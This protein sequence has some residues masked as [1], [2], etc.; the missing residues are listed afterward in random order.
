MADYDYNAGDVT[1][2]ERSAAAKQKQLNTY[3][4]KTINELT[5]YNAGTI[6]TL[7][8]YNKA[9]ANN[10][11]NFNSNT[12][13]S[14]AKYN[15]ATADKLRD[16][17]KATANSTAKYN[18][19]TENRLSDYNKKTARTLADYN[20]GI[21][22]KLAKKNASAANDTALYNANS[23]KNQVNQ[24][25]DNYNFA[26]RQNA[27]LRDVE[28]K[29]ASRKAEADRFEAQRN[30]R[31][32]ALGL[33]GSMNQAM[34]GSTIGNAMSMFSDR[35]D[36]ENSVYWQQ[37]Q[38][39]RNAIQNAYDESYN[40]NQVAK[41]DAV[42]NARKAIRDIQSDLSSNLNNIQGDLISSLGNIRTDLLS[43]LANTQKDLYANKRNIE[44]DRYNSVRGI[45]SDWY[46]NVRE[47]GGDLYNTLNG[48]QADRYS[49]INNVEGDW[50]NNWNNIQ[51]DAF[52][53]LRNLEANLAANLNNINPN[54]YQAP[55][56]VGGE[57][58]RSGG[59]GSGT[60]GSAI[61]RAPAPVAGAITS[62][63]KLP[64]YTIPA[65]AY[66]SIA[67]SDFAIPSDLKTIAELENGTIY[68]KPGTNAALNNIYNYIDSKNI[69]EHNA[70]LLDYI[71]PANAEQT[72]IPRRNTLRGN[73]YYSRLIN[74]FN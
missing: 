44:N 25:L 10:L 26:N 49:S 50:Y 42:I 62:N 70:R 16:Y 55:G 56:L 35:N 14:L 15:K 74:G 60:Y 37:L 31:N 11:A 22:T 43:T 53:N 3:N 59:P 39:N 64:N 28:F 9:T 18:T 32:A 58:S 8:D 19:A 40:Q 5:N 63:A 38:D 6:N 27:S 34:N 65:E 33:L 17:N 2:R 29:Q 1:D 51:A 41:R 71:M 67:L 13:D 54:L 66:N 57:S 45:D 4:K 12:A 20:S 7:R 61:N 36:S 73:D 52:S 48:I 68:K 23:V 69:A 46:N 24:Q 30:L 72:V 47:V 21:Q